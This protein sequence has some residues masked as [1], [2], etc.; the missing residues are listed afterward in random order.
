[1]E[2]RAT[3]ATGSSNDS[4]LFRLLVDRSVDVIWHCDLQFRFS[5]MSPS[6]SS[7]LGYT[8]EECI[9]I[10]PQQTLT[11]AALAIVQ[12]RL[13]SELAKEA[14]MPGSGGNIFIEIDQIHRDGHIVPTELSA[15]FQRDAGGHPIGII[16]VTRNISD[17]RLSEQKQRESTDFLR[18]II[19]CSPL[20]MA[21]VGTDG[22]I[23]FVNR[24]A[25]DTFGYELADIPTMREWWV[26]AYPDPVYREQVVT[27]WS[28][29]VARA[30]AENREIEGREYRVTGKDGRVHDMFIYGIPVAGKT[31][32][33]FQDVGRYKRA[34]A[35]LQESTERFELLAAV[36]PG[37]L[38]DY[39]CRAGNRG[40]FSYLSPYCTEIFGVEPGTLLTD[41]SR[42]LAMLHPSDRERAEAEILRAGRAHDQF[43]L[44]ARFIIPSGSTK[45]IRI[46]A[47]PHR[48]P[49]GEPAVWSGI[50]LDITGK[51][52]EEK[53]RLDESESRFRTL[54]N[55]SDD[56]IVIHDIPEQGVPLGFLDV[57]DTMCQRYGYT[58][59]ELLTM[60]PAD[61]EAPETLPLVPEKMEQL[62]RRGTV[63]WESRHRK[64]SGEVFPVEINLHLIRLGERTLCQGTARDITERVH[65]REMMIHAERQAAIG[66]LAAG[67]AHE[68]NNVLAVIRLHSQQLLHSRAGDAQLTGALTHIEQQSQHGAE[69]VAGLLTFARPKPTRRER[70][71]VATV[72]DHAIALQQQAMATENIRFRSDITPDLAVAANSHRLEQVIVNLIINARHAMQPLGGGE[73]VIAEI[74]SG[75]QASISITDTGIGMDEATLA[76]IFTPFFTTK[77][78]TASGLSTPR[79][80]GLGL[81]VSLS[82]IREYDGTITAE[83]RLHGG[84]TFTVTLPVADDDTPDGRT[85]SNLTPLP[86]DNRLRH[87]IL[88]VDDQPEIAEALGDY[89]RTRN[90]AV[91]CSPSSLAIADALVPDQYDVAI[92]DINMPGISGTALAR[93]LRARQSVRHIIFMSGELNCDSLLDNY[94]DLRDCPIVR[95]PFNLREIISLIQQVPVHPESAPVS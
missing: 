63:T 75:E 18:R 94:H 20:A 34:I 50:M 37:V 1:M 95:K 82:L 81:W 2:P 77:D 23:E 40:R 29:L 46:T 67:I 92:L 48:P 52:L 89:L 30:I 60:G 85:T 76:N 43:N 54:F 91:T 79:G 61:I 42:L 58:R 8:P 12:Q 38:F 55:S 22:I 45:W 25:I 72:I 47:R 62:K 26:K 21:I 66:Q 44:E 11:P 33:L 32:V 39:L 6:I 17:R 56:A 80:T 49:T 16:G 73:L 41:A 10:A 68:F 15:S 5:Y 86:R 28:E 19:D 3:F 64:K 78:R 53:T 71:C 90:C 59:A 87:R 9:A 69:I 84:A 93:L 7:L 35:A 74:R 31:F 14:S 88:I 24:H 57:N 13:G 51:V 70:C 65:A 27:L 83:S 4:D 36:I